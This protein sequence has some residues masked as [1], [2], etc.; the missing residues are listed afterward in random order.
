MRADAIRNRAAIVA[1]ARE[2]I[3]AGGADAGMDDIAAR[4]GVAVGTLYRHFPT[5]G[6]LV[7]A[8]MAELGGEISAML[9]AAISRVESGAVTAHEEIAGLL[10]RIVVDMAADRVLRDAAGTLPPGVEHH[11]AEVLARLV[12][13]ARAEGALRPD[14]TAEDLTLLLATA[15]DETVAE[16]ARARWVTL[17]LRALSAPE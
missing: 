16:A 5:K 12:A 15:P 9:D 4:A 11:A 1:A 8:I 13:G 10:R 3:V 14:V 2:M 6:D 17:A 7:G